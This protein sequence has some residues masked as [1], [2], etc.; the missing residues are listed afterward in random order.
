MLSPMRALLLILLSVAPEGDD[1][2]RFETV[3]DGGFFYFS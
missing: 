1:T 2:I 3:S